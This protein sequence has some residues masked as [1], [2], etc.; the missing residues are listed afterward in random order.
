MRR[1]AF[2]RAMQIWLAALLTFFCIGAAWALAAPYDGTPDEVRHLVRAAGVVQGQVFVTPVMSPDG[3]TGAYQTVP[4]GLVP[5]GLNISPQN[6]FCYHGLPARS[7]AC[8]PQPGPGGKTPV[9]ALT[10]AG[11]YN[12]LYYA[13]VGE[14]LV[15]WPNWTGVMLTRLISAGFCAAFLASAWLSCVRRRR[16]P[17][18]TGALLVAVTPAVF[19]LAGGVN[20]NAVEIMAG[21]SLAAAA[22][23]LLLEEESPDVRSLMRRAAIAAIAIAQFR[24]IGPLFVVGW[25]IVLLLPPVRARLRQLRARRST[26]F[27]SAGILTSCV[28]GAAWTIAFKAADVGHYATQHYTTAEALGIELLQR[29]P[30]YLQQIVDGFSYYDT[31]PPDVIF[32]AWAMPLGLLLIAAFAWGTPVQRYRLALLITGTLAIPVIADVATV[33][34]YRFPF[35]GRYFMPLAVGIPLLAAFTAGRAGVLPQARQA[36]LVRIMTVLMLPFQLLSLGYVMDRWQSGL[37]VGRSLNPLQ[38]S[39]HPVSGSALPLL[40]M[41]IGLT[42]LGALVWRATRPRDGQQSTPAHEGSGTAGLD[43]ASA[44]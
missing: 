9:T 29:L 42:A 44:G 4:S 26:W 11:R 1:P 36:S 33:N 31:N 8:G 27:W 3:I 19:Q 2:S 5:H 16:S 43:Y 18:L 37:G 7:A 25:L 22:I 32:L 24:A 28:T 23:P 34:T 20:P 39:W 13:A 35:Q 40:L 10:G 17:L 21:I 14:P 38:G 12:P 6:L 30:S 15:R 41:T